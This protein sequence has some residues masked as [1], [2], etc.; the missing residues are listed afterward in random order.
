[1]S[2]RKMAKLG[3]MSSDD[4]AAA[5]RENGKL[6]GRPRWTHLVCGRYECPYTVAR[7]EDGWRQARCPDH[8]RAKLHKLYPHTIPGRA[9]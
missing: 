6:G 1:M 7:G 4:K 2:S 3:A 5:A 8:P 9:Q